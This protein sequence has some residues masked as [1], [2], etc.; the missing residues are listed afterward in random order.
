MTAETADSLV[1]RVRGGDRGAFREL[2]IAFERDVRFHVGAFAVAAGM[3]DEVVQATFVS[4]YQNLG[5]YRGEGAF[6][7]WLK[8]IARNHVLRL[9]R[10]QRRFADVS[11]DALEEMLTTSALD[12]VERMDEL[13]HQ[14]R[15]LRRCLEALPA[16]LRALVEARHLEGLS[17]ASA[18]AR[19]AR[20]EIWVRVT[21][22]RARQALRR[23]IEEQARG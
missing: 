13:E 1:T 19:L 23:C 21:L 9:L 6:L 14:T 8:A 20:T 12:E 22:C 16:K 15:T 7:G 4:A 3:V 11:G 5:Q 10:E 17:T 2:V 18:A